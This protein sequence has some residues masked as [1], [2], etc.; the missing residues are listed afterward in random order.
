MVVICR[1]KHRVW[2]R[3]RNSSFNFNDAFFFSHVLHN[4]L[5]SA[6]GLVR[7]QPGKHKSMS[8]CAVFIL[9]VLLGHTD[10]QN[11]IS[12]VYVSV[13]RQIMPNGLD[14]GLGLWDWSWRNPYFANRAA[15]H[16]GL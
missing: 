9:E 1:T 12:Q 10:E 6:A 15:P 7:G 11:R 8:V 14:S 16:P 2:Q 4:L 3:F 13:A 5:S